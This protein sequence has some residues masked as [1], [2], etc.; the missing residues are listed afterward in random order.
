M[1]KLLLLFIAFTIIST[2]AMAESVYDRVMR[3]GTIECGYFVEPPFTVRNEA[4]GEFSGLT[5]DLIE[6][7]AKD[8]NLKVKWKEQISFATFPED[9]NNNK[10]DMVCGSV[11]VLP[12]GG[13][14]DYTNAYVYVSMLGYVRPENTM[15]D[16]PFQEVD[17]SKVSISG[18]DGE[19]ATT[20][21]QKL[22]PEAKMKILPQLSNI[23]EMLL[24]VATGKA[25][26]GFVLPSVFKDFN[27][28]NPGKLRKAGLDRPLSSY[29][30]SFGI[31]RGQEEFKA[32]MNNA[33]RQLTVSGELRALFEKHDSEG[34][35][36][37]PIVSKGH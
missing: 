34:F 25:D 15:F 12:R 33:L 21:A 28:F 26:I 10:Y 1:K 37:Y 2:P 7:I 23:S 16:K 19:G 27:N 35:F 29:D 32:L 11:F 22:L 5:V 17:W 6:L 36:D 18:L 13:R 4:T 24:V 14:M 8:L 31:A 30:V 3:T 9:L 20:A